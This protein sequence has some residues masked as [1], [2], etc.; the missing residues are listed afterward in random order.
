M[1][2]V[3][4]IPTRRCTG[5]G[6]HFQKS[7]L[8]RIVR[9]PEGEISLDATGKNYQEGM[10][11]TI[12]NANDSYF[13]PDMQRGMERFIF[14]EIARNASLNLAEQDPEKVF[15]MENNAATR[16]FGRGLSWSFTQTVANIP[17]AKRAVFYAAVDT[18]FPLVTDVAIARLPIFRRPADQI[19]TVNKGIVLARIMKNLGCTTPQTIFDLISL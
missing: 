3:K 12:L 11:K 2:T 8:I 5:C 19:S 9:S 1:A 14:E 10:P 16:F 4:K 7:A 13:K 15:G 6:E 17:P 18:A